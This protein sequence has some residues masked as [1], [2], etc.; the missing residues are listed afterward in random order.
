VCEA[1]RFLD[2]KVGTGRVLPDPKTIRAATLMSQEVGG[3][4]QVDKADV[5]AMLESGAPLDA[6]DPSVALTQYAPDGVALVELEDGTKL[7]LTM[8]V[9]AHAELAWPDGT[10]VIF[11]YGAAAPWL[12]KGAA[13][14]LHRDSRHDADC[15]HV[16]NFPHRILF[17]PPADFDAKE[18]LAQLKMTCSPIGRG[19]S[20]ADWCCP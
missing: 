1:P 20:T 16:D 10:G 15:R 4:R 7:R 13:P 18:T 8:F 9:G 14:F 12:P 2:V 6:C 5:V 3:R 19:A 17:Q 11:D